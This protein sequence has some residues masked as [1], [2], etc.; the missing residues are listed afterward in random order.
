MFK[1]LGIAYKPNS[2]ANR[3]GQTGK[4]CYPGLCHSNYIILQLTDFEAAEMH[5][6]A[7]VL[8][9]NLPLRPV[10]YMPVVGYDARLIL[11]PQLHEWLASVWGIHVGGGY[12]II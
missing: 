7:V 11:C 6:V 10:R 9:Q 8:Q 3:M 4:S 12:Q 1:F 2:I 5:F